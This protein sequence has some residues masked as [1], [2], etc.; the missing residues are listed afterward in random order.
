MEWFLIFKVSGWEL[1]PPITNFHLSLNKSCYK[2]IG[3]KLKNG[4]ELTSGVVL[5]INLSFMIFINK[6]LI[7]DKLKLT[8]THRYSTNI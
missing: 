1:Q 6:C 2:L 8:I 4:P 5:F 3:R 7:N